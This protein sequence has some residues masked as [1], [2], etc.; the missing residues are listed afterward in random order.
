M[1]ARIDRWWLVLTHCEGVAS[2]A[3]VLQLQSMP[4]PRHD[5][6]C[7]PCDASAK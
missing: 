1:V 5:T 6:V 7:L 4:P 2:P 3:C